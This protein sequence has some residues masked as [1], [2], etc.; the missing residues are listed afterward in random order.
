MTPQ[1]Q[2][3]EAFTLPGV[4]IIIPWQWVVSF[5]MVGDFRWRFSSRYLDIMGDIVFKSG[6]VLV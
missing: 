5:G 6:H 3:T 2:D 4:R 1:C